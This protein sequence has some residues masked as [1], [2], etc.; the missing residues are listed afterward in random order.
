[1]NRSKQPFNHE[2]EHIDSD[3]IK[4]EV[5]L[6]DMPAEWLGELM[7][8]LL[9]IGVNDV[10]YTPIYMKKNRP[11][12]LLSVLLS[13]H[14]LDKVKRLIFTE[15]TTFGIRYSP[16]TVHR[17]GRKFK[18]VE[19][20]WGPVSVKQ[21]LLGNQVVQESPEFEDCRQIAEKAGV[22]VKAVY[23]AVWKILND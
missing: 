3:M 18:T 5:N 11:A 4:I 21:A 8:R 7:D 6:D 9:A 14:L 15:T 2:R 1:M 10:Y 20:K 19:T 12:V 13:K 23:Q 22:P 16:W 17:L